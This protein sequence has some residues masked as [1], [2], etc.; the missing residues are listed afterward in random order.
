MRLLRGIR[1][2]NDQLILDVHQNHAAKKS[3]TNFSKPLDRS[4]VPE[5]NNG[6]ERTHGHSEKG[7]YKNC[8]QQYDFVK[9]TLQDTQYLVW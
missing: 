9:S 3:R 7:G 1:Y 5:Y 4:H 6:I 2:G 8:K